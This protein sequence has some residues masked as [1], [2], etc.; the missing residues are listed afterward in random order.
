MEPNSNPL[1]SERDAARMAL[2]FKGLADPTR[3]KILSVLLGGE[4]RVSDLAERI[5]TSQTAVSHQL[6]V[7]RDLRFVS[8]RREGTQIFYRI[9][10]EHIEDLFNKAFAHG[11]HLSD[12]QGEPR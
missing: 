10:D 11:K 9:D 3:L 8:S 5:Q 1:L 2:T 12:Q 6:R 4:I 7:L